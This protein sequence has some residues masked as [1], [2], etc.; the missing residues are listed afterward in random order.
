MGLDLAK[1]LDRMDAK[2]P[3]PAGGEVR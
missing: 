3:K 1:E 2:Q